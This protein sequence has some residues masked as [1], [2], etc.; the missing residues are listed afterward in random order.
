[1]RSRAWQSI[2][3]CDLIKKFADTGSSRL[4]LLYGRGFRP[5]V[6]IKKADD[7]DYFGDTT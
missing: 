5:A 6:D 7:N 3:R 2:R 4:Q 1:M